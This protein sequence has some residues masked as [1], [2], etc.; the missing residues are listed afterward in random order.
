MT[1]IVLQKRG[2]KIA[3]CILTGDAERS[4]EEP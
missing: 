4:E 3:K 1:T 2:Q